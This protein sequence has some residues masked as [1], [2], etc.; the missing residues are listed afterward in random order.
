MPHPSFQTRQLET[1]V[2]STRIVSLASSVWS[3]VIGIANLAVLL[4]AL[5]FSTFGF[6]AV[7]LM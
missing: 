5:I 6:A 1:A 3:G 4:P 2:T 7:V